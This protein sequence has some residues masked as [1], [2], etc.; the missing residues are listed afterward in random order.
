[1]MVHTKYDIT[2]ITE[3]QQL[4][5]KS[6][7]TFSKILKGGI[8]KKPQSCEEDREQSRS[9]RTSLYDPVE[10]KREQN[11]DLPSACRV[12]TCRVCTILGK[13]VEVGRLVVTGFEALEE[14]P[15]A[16]D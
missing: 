4:Q 5:H 16:C 11:L 1:M 9:L 8:Q 12:S 7:H 15:A 10:V 2:Q 6:T 13:Q 14:E 3:E